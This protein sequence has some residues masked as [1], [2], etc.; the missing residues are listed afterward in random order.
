MAASLIA[1]PAFA[2][3]SRNGRTFSSARTG[4]S[5]TAWA[6]SQKDSNPPTIRWYNCALTNGDKITK[7]QYGLWDQYGVL[8]D[9]LVGSFRNASSCATTQQWVRGSSSYTLN[10]DGFYWQLGL[11]NGKDRGYLY[12][13][14]DVSW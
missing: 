5:S 1:A 11:I 12:G 4:F 6:D 2:E 8:P 7:V 14:V 9:A 3:G 10:P 13:S